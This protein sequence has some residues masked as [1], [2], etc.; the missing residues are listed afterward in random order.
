MCR[1]PDAAHNEDQ[2]VDAAREF[3][4]EVAR[5]A[6]E[7]VDIDS[8]DVAAAGGIID[9][10]RD[11]QLGLTDA[12]LVVIAARYQTTRLL[13]LDERHFVP[14]LRYGARLFHAAAS[15]LMTSD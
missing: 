1:S 15:R 6:F 11:L 14:W 13:T 3:F 2:L 4:D 12:S 7:L 9:R 10:Y 8:G 5:D